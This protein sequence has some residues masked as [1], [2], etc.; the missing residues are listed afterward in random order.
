ML[1]DPNSIKPSQVYLKPQTVKY[2][3]VCIR[4]NKTEE[5]PP[6][7]I[8]RQNKDGKLVALDGHN[9]IAYM[10]YLNQPIEVHLAK[11]PNDGLDETSEAN[12]TRNVD[13]KEKF[14]HVLIEQAEVEAQGISTFSDLTTKYP[15]L[16]I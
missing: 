14:D 3:A 12:I 11:S 8:V 10:S 2:I 7:P 1:V 16:F 5:L 9:L 6:P 13:L 4:N 15:E